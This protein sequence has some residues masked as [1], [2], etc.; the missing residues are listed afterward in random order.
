VSELLDPWGDAQARTA[1]DLV[2]P[3]DAA[4]QQQS[5]S[6]LPTAALPA[7]KTPSADAPIP[8]MNND[9]I[10][11]PEWTPPRQQTLPGVT[12]QVPAPVKTTPM[13]TYLI[14]TGIAGALGYVLWRS[15]KKNSG[16]VKGLD[17][18]EEGGLSEMYALPVSETS[19]MVVEEVKKEKSKTRVRFP[20]SGAEVWIAT[21]D[22]LGE[23]DAKK[24]GLRERD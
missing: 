21:A 3:W 14:L 5:N 17:D 11:P 1:T 24:Q 10:A 19:Y 20:D 15:M 22:L 4:V 7:A 2:D 13:S 6:P 8:L 16:E 12:I 9:L 18:L 23:Q